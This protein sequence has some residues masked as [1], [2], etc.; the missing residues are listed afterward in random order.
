MV[1]MVLMVL[2]FLN[3]GSVDN[4]RVEKVPV[5]HGN[6]GDPQHDVRGDSTGAALFHLAH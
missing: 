3:A 5:Q 1:L 2:L 6:T 4:E